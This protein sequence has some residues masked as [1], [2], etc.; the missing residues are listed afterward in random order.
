[1]QEKRRGKFWWEFLNFVQR[2]LE[3]NLNLTLTFRLLI[4]ARRVDICHLML[5]HIQVV[6]VRLVAVI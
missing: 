1:M 4:A 6:M 3:G 5:V 2:L